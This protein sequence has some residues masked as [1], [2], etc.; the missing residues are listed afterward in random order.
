MEILK[1]LPAL[2]QKKPPAEVE[3]RELPAGSFLAILLSELSA[4][5]FNYCRDELPAPNEWRSSDLLDSAST[6]LGVIV[7]SAFDLVPDVLL[8]QPRKF[9][10]L[11]GFLSSREGSVR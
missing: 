4:L 8:F 5:G 11:L 3:N 7:E 1:S 9:Q 2:K 6:R 10:R